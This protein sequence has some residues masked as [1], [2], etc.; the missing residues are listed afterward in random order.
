MEDKKDL[1]ENEVLEETNLE[2]EESAVSEE[3]LREREIEYRLSEINVI[4][5]EYQNKLYDEEIEKMSKEEY[6][7]L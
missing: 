5:D 1:L 6:S 4:I 2:V 3:V 7:E